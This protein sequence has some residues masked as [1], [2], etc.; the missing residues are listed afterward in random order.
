MVWYSFW[1]ARHRTYSLS[2]I[3]CCSR[4]G[5][6]IR[7]QTSKTGRPRV[8]CA[9]R[10]QGLGCDFGGT[11][12]D[13][14]E[15]QIAWYLENFIIPE[16]YQKRILEANQKL[17]AIYNDHEG[18]RTRL[19]NYLKQLKKQHSWGHISDTEYLA[20]YGETERQLND[21]YLSGDKAAEIGRFA[22]FLSNVANAWLQANPEQRNKLARTLFDEIRLDSG[23]RV[24]APKPRP[25]L[26]PFFRLSY[27]C[28]ARDIASDPEGIRTL[29]LRRDRP[30]C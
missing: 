24:V 18:Q 17:H 8:Y 22:D 2:C 6:K 21:L 15:A 3:A 28:H 26:D 16:D 14:Y 9:S 1:G 29:D 5:G 11:F 10:S 4:C 19:E 13:I 20:E 23:G 27:E 30:I 25:E 12:L 7:I